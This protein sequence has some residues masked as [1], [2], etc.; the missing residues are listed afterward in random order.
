MGK[1][2]AAELLTVA[3]AHRA[4]VELCWGKAKL[5]SEWEQLARAQAQLKAKAKA[6][7][8]AKDEGLTLRVATSENKTGFSGVSLSRPLCHPLRPYRAQVW[9][10]DKMC[11][12]GRFATPEEAALAIARAVAQPQPQPKPKPQLSE[13]AQLTSAVALL[14]AQAEALCK[15]AE[16]GRTLRSRPKNKTGF[17]GVYLSNPGTPKPYEAQVRRGGKMVHLGAFAT[18]EEAA[19]AIARS[20][21]E[22]VRVAR[23]ARAEE[24][25]RAVQK[26]LRESSAQKAAQRWLR[27]WRSSRAKAAAQLRRDAREAKG[28]ARAQA[29]QQRRDAR[30]ATAAAR[31]QADRVLPDAEKQ[32]AAGDDAVLQPATLTALRGVLIAGA[33]ALAAAEP[34]AALVTCV[35]I[36]GTVAI[37]LAAAAERHVALDAAPVAVVTASIASARLPKRLLADARKLLALHCQRRRFAAAKR[38]RAESGASTPLGAKEI[39]PLMNPAMLWD[40]VCGEVQPQHPYS[41]PSLPTLTPPTPSP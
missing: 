13:E 39:A 16:E 41:V 30:E 32:L 14:K 8:Q 3:A 2:R 22:Q 35:A 17:A 1:T 12:V 40:G 19:L 25:K 18:A 20:P 36:T 26:R 29:D 23:A 24:R 10:G 27:R 9:R 6:R 28:T 7:Q 5:P 31:A 15:A 37:A 33:A 11:W 38:L 34:A 21:E 4:F